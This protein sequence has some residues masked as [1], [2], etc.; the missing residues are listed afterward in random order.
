[1]G[2]FYSK[3]ILCG[4]RA[5]EDNHLVKVISFGKR[6]YEIFCV[7]CLVNLRLSYINKINLENYID[8]INNK[9]ERK[10]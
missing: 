10:S 3:Y 9:D 2:V 7:N 5:S 4:S 1:M 8:Y 6:H